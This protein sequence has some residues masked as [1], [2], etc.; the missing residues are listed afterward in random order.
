MDGP[1][2][3]SFGVYILQRNR[4]ERVCSNVNEFNNRSQVLKESCDVQRNFGKE[5][6][7]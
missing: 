6:L 1:R 7:L 5:L 2:F 4:F 3:S